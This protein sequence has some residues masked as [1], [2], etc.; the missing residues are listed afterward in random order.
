MATACLE[1]IVA[2]LLHLRHCLGLIGPNS[3]TADRK[4]YG[5]LAV[6]EAAFLLDHHQT[7]S[8][9]AEE[10]QASA[11]IMSQAEKLD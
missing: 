3:E 4:A 9:L 8:L 1:L 7:S 11:L 10:H 6:W 5:S 2:G